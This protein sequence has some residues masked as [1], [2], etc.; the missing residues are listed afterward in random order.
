MSAPHWGFV[1]INK[2]DSA[3]DFKRLNTELEALWHKIL[4]NMLMKDFRD[5]KI[6]GGDASGIAEEVI[7]YILQLLPN[8]EENEF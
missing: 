3:A 4:G 7:Q 8:A 1:P 6:N 5:L 2:L